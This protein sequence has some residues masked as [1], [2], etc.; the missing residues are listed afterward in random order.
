MFGRAFQGSSDHFFGSFLHPPSPRIE[1][2]FIRIDMDG[3][4]TFTGQHVYCATTGWHTNI[5][6]IHNATHDLFHWTVAHDMATWFSDCH[7][8]RCAH[9]Q[10][11]GQSRHIGKAS[12]E[13]S[14]RSSADLSLWLFVILFGRHAGASVFLL[15]FGKFVVGFF[16]CQTFSFISKS[17][18]FDVFSNFTLFISF[19]M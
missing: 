12:T 18:D 15:R 16:G 7:I 4:V 13:N 19:S 9:G 14:D 1:F 2:P 8:E 6:R 10:F 5:C 11:D 3:D 17:L